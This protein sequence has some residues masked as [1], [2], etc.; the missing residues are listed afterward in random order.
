MKFAFFFSILFLFNLGNS[1]NT[2]TAQTGLQ[3]DGTTM[4]T[5]FKVFGNCGMC[6]KRIEKAAKIE[7]VSAAEWDVD[8][9]I[10]TITFDEKVVKPSKVHQAVAAVGHDTELVRADNTVYADLPECCQYDRAN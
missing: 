2:T 3:A 9:K 6:K 7:G 5:K 10:L 8:T 4:T 1:V